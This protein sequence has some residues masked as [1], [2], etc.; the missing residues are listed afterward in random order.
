MWAAR[1]TGLTTVDGLGASVVLLARGRPAC[2]LAFLAS[3]RLL[4]QAD[5]LVSQIRGDRSPD[6]FRLRHTEACLEL[7]EAGIQRRIDEE[8]NPCACFATSSHRR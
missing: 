3:D 1:L 8:A 4:S 5:T 7:V 6:R 2:R